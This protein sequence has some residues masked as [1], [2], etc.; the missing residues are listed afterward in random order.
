MGKHHQFDNTDDTVL[1]GET[2]GPEPDTEGRPSLPWSGRVLFAIICGPLIGL[3]VILV[4]SSTCTYGCGQQEPTT[5]V[6]VGL[7]DSVTAPDPTT[8]AEFATSLPSSSTASPTAPALAPTRST[9][10]PAPAVRPTQS[11]PVAATA[12]PTPTP[13]TASIPAVRRVG[14]VLGVAGMCMDLDGAVAVKGNR[15]QVWTCNGTVAQTVTVETDETL[16]LLG[17]CVRG[18]N[19]VVTAGT[20]T[21]VWTCDG[22]P[23]QRWRFV[24][25]RI[26]NP[27]TGLC[28]DTEGRGSGNGTRLTAVACDDGVSQRWILPPPG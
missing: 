6:T 15:V 24:G 28:L 25:N 20:L 21:E 3:V 14:T 23:D 11:R 19:G 26:V 4:A 9:P 2:P 13:T 7:S 10:A 8:T 12:A 27:G 17:L 16:R 18:L 5:P 22:Q 1:I